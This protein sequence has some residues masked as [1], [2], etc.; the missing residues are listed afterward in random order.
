LEYYLT[1]CCRGLV[2]LTNLPN[3]FPG[4]SNR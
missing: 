4:G 2:T 3:S 1:T